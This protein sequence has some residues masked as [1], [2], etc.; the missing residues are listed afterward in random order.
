MGAA[1]T[2][3]ANPNATRANGS[4]RGF[5]SERKSNFTSIFCSPLKSPHYLS[6]RF[7]VPSM[8]AIADGAPKCHGGG[9]GDEH[10]DG[11]PLGL[12]PDLGAKQAYRLFAQALPTPWADDK[13]LAEINLF[14]L[15]AIER[16]GD[17]RPGI[18]EQNRHV[19]PGEPSPSSVA[20]ARERSSDC[21]VPH[22]ES[23][24][25]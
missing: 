18:L 6:A 22:R 10:F 19:L 4:K 8:I 12:W 23:I 7:P 9:V 5:I 25:G 17:D 2:K 13:E 20:P 15:L 3:R 11:Q 1:I 24:G 21:D 16:V 14:R